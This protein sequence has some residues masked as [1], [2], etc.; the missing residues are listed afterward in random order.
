MD[1]LISRTDLQRKIAAGAVTVVEALPAKYFNDKHLPG[2]LNLP[3]DQVASLAPRLL[4]DRNAEIVVYCANAACR[5]SA[6][7]GQALRDLGYS[8]V[9]EYTEGKQDWVDAGLAVESSA[10]AAE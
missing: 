6:I 4:P 5:N 7:A 8:R 2:A 1:H 10:M 9:L 3:H